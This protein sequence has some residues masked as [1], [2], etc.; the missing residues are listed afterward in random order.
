MGNKKNNQ[1][2]KRIVWCISF[3]FMLVVFGYMYG[4]S[5]S[6]NAWNYEYNEENDEIAVNLNQIDAPASG[7]L[8]F[9][10]SVAI[11]DVS[12]D[13][14]NCATNAVY[15][16]GM[17]IEERII[18]N[19]PIKL[20]FYVNNE[21]KSTEYAYA[22]KNVNTSKV[23]NEKEMW[24][25]ISDIR[26]IMAKK[27]K[28]AL[29]WKVYDFYLDIYAQ[30][31]YV[32]PETGET[33]YDHYYT[34]IKYVNGNVCINEDECIYNTI[35]D[36]INDGVE[37]VWLN[38][39]LNECVTIP[40][41]TSLTIDLN[42]GKIE[43]LSGGITIN[44]SGNLVVENSSNEYSYII[45]SGQNVVNNNSKATFEIISNRI[46]L[47]GRSSNSN[48]VYNLGDF[49]LNSNAF[50]HCDISVYNLGNYYMNAGFLEGTSNGLYNAS[51]GNSIINGGVVS[52]INGNGI[53]NE[54][55]GV[56]SATGDV[57]ITNG[58]KL[59]NKYPVYNLGK[60][61]ISLNSGGYIYTNSAAGLT[62]VYNSGNLVLN[63]GEIF[64]SC[65]GVY[66]SSKNKTAI[67]EMNGGII[68]VYGNCT[69]YKEAVGVW[70]G[71]EDDSLSAKVNINGGEIM[72]IGFDDEATYYAMSLRK[73]S[74][75][76]KN[77]TI[78][79]TDYGIYS[80][81]DAKVLISENTIVE[82]ENIGVYNYCGK[83]RVLD[84]K[85]NSNDIG[86]KNL[87]GD[88][89]VLRSNVEGMEYG[90]YSS[91]GS[92]E[93]GDNKKDLTENTIVVGQQYGI[94]MENEAKLAFYNGKI[95]GDK[96]IF[97]NIGDISKYGELKESTETINSIA[98]NSVYYEE[99]VVDN[100]ESIEN[101][102]IDETID[103]NVGNMEIVENKAKDIVGY[104]YEEN[105]LTIHVIA[106]IGLMAFLFVGV[107]LITKKK[108]N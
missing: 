65:V 8:G 108:T 68:D 101:L 15:I 42:G 52:S 91:S 88:V 9:G 59:Q 87:N 78:N 20:T 4:G 73:T 82:S 53:Y 17:D 30:L 18:R 71:V 50:I 99:K 63:Q 46:R 94:Y 2:A 32:D 37:K 57:L 100:F 5:V 103:S 56:V 58:S 21:K 69:G 47:G 80:R 104:K 106:V 1:L 16:G 105:N 23:S 38:G 107:C 12:T 14:K 83:I 24:L 85:I 79:G 77:A 102:E 74:A 43:C 34:Y 22:E 55:D 97:G 93:V 45:G 27:N 60:F 54:D 92:I 39:T 41:G 40:E 76:I 66:N 11:C 36:A 96:S 6:I 61:D 81:Y 3:L 35:K 33:P 25:S 7:Y 89:L 44:N 10:A 49:I 51:F 48:C 31:N 67:F 62:A 64:A 90:V 86:I 70:S 98:Y 29:K 95:L 84:S 13:V 19:T 26:E 75:Y 72:A 28:Q